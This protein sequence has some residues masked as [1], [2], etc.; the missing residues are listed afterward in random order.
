MGDA[1]DSMVDMRRAANV[2]RLPGRGLTL[3]SKLHYLSALPRIDGVEDADDLATGVAD[4][5][6]AVAESWSGP[7][8]CWPCTSRLTA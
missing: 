8:A 5:V 2:P 4:L 1:L 3:D 6:S 7:A